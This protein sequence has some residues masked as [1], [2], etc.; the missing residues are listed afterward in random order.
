MQRVLA[1]VIFDRGEYE[2]ALQIYARAYALL[3]RRLGGYGKRT[4]TDELNML[5]RRIERLAE[6]DAQRAMEWCHK[7]RTLWSD[8]TIPIQQRDALIAMCDVH[9]TNILW[10][11]S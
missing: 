2:R 11:L 3:G 10:N 1:D 8:P 5:A 4:F 7:L 9:E 6:E